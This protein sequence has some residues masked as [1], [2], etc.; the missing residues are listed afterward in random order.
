LGIPVEIGSKLPGGI[1]LYPLGT[2]IDERLV[3]GV[4]DFED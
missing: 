4:V 3:S 1:S 2:Q